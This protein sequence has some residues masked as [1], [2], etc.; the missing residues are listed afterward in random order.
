MGVSRLESLRHSR[1]LCD[2][3]PHAPW[4]EPT[5]S[6]MRD[7]LP[8]SRA[9]CTCR[10]TVMPLSLLQCLGANFNFNGGRPFGQELGFD[11]RRSTR[12]QANSPC[13]IAMLPSA[14]LGP[15]AEVQFFQAFMLG[16][17]VA[18]S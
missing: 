4:D 11:S 5:R 17:F 8:L 1:P 16:L 14:T 7:R 12:G 18:A 2:K 15:P 9:A 3:R 6:A 13:H 10:L